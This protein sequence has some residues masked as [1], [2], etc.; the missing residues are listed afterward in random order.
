[1]FVTVLGAIWSSAILFG[2]TLAFAVILQCLADKI[3]SSGLDRWQTAY[4]Y[5]VCPGVVCHEFGH[6]VGCWITGNQVAKAEFFT[7]DDPTRLGRVWVR[8]PRGWRGVF[9]RLVIATGPVWFGC[10]VIS[11]LSKL[12][13]GSVVVVHIE[14]YVD[15]SSVP[16]VVE[17][18]LGCFGAGCQLFWNVLIDV[19][20]S[21]IRAILWLY[22]S[23]CIAS[24]I[25][26]SSADLS[27]ARSGLI[28][29]VLIVIGLAVVPVLGRWIVGGVA[30]ALP[31]VFVVH[32]IM[33]FCIL[34][35]S[36]VLLSLRLMR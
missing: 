35:S 27:L 16:S 28:G 14:E 31:I 24:E 30:L 2:M 17:Y 13:L 20:A 12:L 11:L 3:R 26:M 10:L 5:F 34:V 18:L 1:M 22:L 15:C 6:C 33:A 9:C 32:S 21:P 4:W 25:G 23:F 7:P 36:L 29:I 8:C 19:L